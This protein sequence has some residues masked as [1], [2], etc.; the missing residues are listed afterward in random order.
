LTT[1]SLGPTVVRIRPLMPFK[2]NRGLDR[3]HPRCGFSLLE[4]ILAT[5]ILAGSSLMLATLISNGAN[6]GSRAQ[7]RVEALLVAQT[8]IDETLAMRHGEVFQEEQPFSDTSRWSYRLNAESRETTGLMVISAEVYPVE[9]EGGLPD[10]TEEPVI[11]LVRWYLPRIQPADS[12]GQR[13][14]GGDVP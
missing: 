4:V 10:S 9:D 12:V 13:L 3:L 7:D 5:A 6:L 2:K 14:I 11:R 1:G 8:L